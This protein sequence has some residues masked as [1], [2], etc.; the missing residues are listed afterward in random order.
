MREVEGFNKLG[1]KIPIKCPLNKKECAEHP[2][3]RGWACKNYEGYDLRHPFDK[4]YTDNE[5]IKIY[6][7]FVNSIAFIME[8][9]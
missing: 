9:E 5:Y 4:A 7:K 1:L 6:C 2:L 8:K 3:S